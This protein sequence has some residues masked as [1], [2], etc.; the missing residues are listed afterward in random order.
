MTYILIKLWMLARHTIVLQ[1]SSAHM[2]KVATIAALCTLMVHDPQ[3]VGGGGGWNCMLFF[4]GFTSFIAINVLT[5]ASIGQ[6]MPLYFFLLCTLLFPV[7]VLC[8]IICHPLTIMRTLLL[9]VW[10]PLSVHMQ[11]QGQQ[12]VTDTFSRQP[13]CAWFTPSFFSFCWKFFPKLLMST[14]KWHI[15]C[16]WYLMGSTNL[17]MKVLETWLIALMLETVYTAELAAKWRWYMEQVLCGFNLVSLCQLHLHHK[18]VMI[19]C[20]G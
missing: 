15:A 3:L 20:F 17:A 14:A 11:L 4:F 12:W 9:F 5:I 19:Y 10:W 13:Q 6:C 8:A 7:P 2:Y 1:A 18:L 16:C